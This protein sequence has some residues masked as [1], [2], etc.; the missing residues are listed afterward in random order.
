MDTTPIFK[1]PLIPSF[2]TTTLATHQHSYQPAPLLCEHVS[3]P[4]HTEPP[5]KQY[6]P[7]ALSIIM[8][9]NHFFFESSLIYFSTA[10]AYA[11]LPL[12]KIPLCH[13]IQ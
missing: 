3:Y 5:P 1:E 11:F 7:Q 2:T 9:P 4:L 12:H 13:F 6:E 8:P 10:A